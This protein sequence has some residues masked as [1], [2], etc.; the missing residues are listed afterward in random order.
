M[1][2]MKLPTHM[3]SKTLAA[4]ALALAA[5]CSGSFGQVFYTGNAT[6]WGNS[7]N[8]SSGSVPT[9]ATNIEFGNYTGVNSANTGTTNQPVN[10][11]SFTRNSST[12]IVTMSAGGG[13]VNASGTIS[14]TAGASE[15]FMRA[16]GTLAAAN[17]TVNNAFNLGSRSAAGL[18]SQIGNV[19]ISGT[20][21]INSGGT[22]HAASLNGT[23][24]LGS[25]EMSGGT[26]N[27]VSGNS[28]ANGSG[29][30]TTN[31]I[32]VSRLNGSGTI[33]G[34]KTG[35]TSITTGHLIVSGTTNGTFSGNITNG[36]ANN[37]VQISKAGSSTLTLSGNNSYSGVTA[38]SAGTLLVSGGG[39][40]GTTSLA[41][42]GGSLQLGAANVLSNN[43]TMVLSGGNFSTGATT[44]FGETLGTLDLET[45]ATLTLALGTGVHSLNF[46]NS[47]GI[48]WTGS[49][50]TITGW[51]GTAGF[52]GTAGR[53]FFGNN[54]T[55]LSP[56]QLSQINFTGYANGASILSTGEIVAI[57]EPAT[58]ALLAGSL[59]AVLVFRRRR[60]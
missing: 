2:C 39:L 21:T 13:G 4:V 16:G 33:T 12:T 54:A 8:W 37:V 58:W 28:L 45:A 26:F 42:S 3:N 30:G 38:V 10:D 34:A 59:T 60:G 24:S 23:T 32:S 9:S 22:L 40:T 29:N 51:T 1:N 5:T 14:S 56:G 53:I 44:G 31:T 36:L 55:G 57:P 20:T 19:T 7:T 25:L 47:S 17:L 11:V 52:S 27:L 15:V 43:A 6:T 46:A 48:D 49:T 35:A 18:N 50:L 41:V